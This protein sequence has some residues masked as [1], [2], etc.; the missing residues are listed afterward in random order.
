MSLDRIER[1]D[2]ELN[3]VVSISPGEV[4]EQARRL[5]RELRA[6]RWRGP[7]HGIPVGLKDVIDC[8]G[9]ST[10]MG[11]AFCQDNVA[12]R[13]ASAVRRLRRAGAV[14]IGKLHTQEYAY[15]ATGEHAFTGACRN[16]SDLER[17]SGGSSSGPAAAVA[18]G[19]C[20]AALGTDTGGS[21]RIP[22]SLCGVVGLKPTMGRISRIGVAPLSW[23]LDHVGVIT[24]SIADNAALLAVVSGF[25]RAD[26][27]SR[28]RR[29]EDFTRY[30]GADVRGLS[31][32]VPSSYFE[33][34]D[35]EI[36][37]GVDTAL[38]V[39]KERGCGISLVAV[40]QLDR[41]IKAQRTVLTTE[42]YAVHRQR[43]EEQPQL[44]QDSVRQRL[45]DGS[46]I[47][48]WRYAESYRLRDEAR[49][50][51]DEALASV[52]VLVTA[53]V[54]I[55]APLLGQ[56]ATSA[57]GLVET[58]QSA[59]TRLTGVTNF[60]GHPSLTLPCGRSKLGLPLGVQLIGRRWEEALLYR[61]GQTLE[62]SCPAI[63][64]G[65]R[66]LGRG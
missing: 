12:S 57:A 53:T 22:A 41:F 46:M 18:S 27:E 24:S 51:F 25:D 58:V 59:L 64:F 4:L 26:P 10:T 28:R 49:R 65:S 50:V 14:L 29:P 66:G 44:F 1:H 54:P 38:R 20:L 13:D 11:S 19:M 60:S 32:G 15:G 43:F 6:G 31:I 34:L 30:L 42:A 48:A 16:P 61:F 52:D 55:L 21:V 37:S 8:R 35:P 40:P 62:D 5:D 7:L 17:M 36:R 39:W 23:T 3:A 9:S 56:Q 45:E 47:S 63:A 2:P 33:H